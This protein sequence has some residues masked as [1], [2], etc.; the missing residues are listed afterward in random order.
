M[1]RYD[2]QVEVLARGACV[3][4]GRLLLCHSKGAANTFLPGGHVEFRERA[5]EALR[6]EIAEE[7][8]LDAKVGRFLGCVEHAFAQKG[9]PHAEVNLVFVVTIEGLSSDVAPPSK[10]EKIEFSWVDMAGLD[11]TA[12]EPAALRRELPRWLDP[13]F[14]GAGW[15]SW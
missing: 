12:L 5:E 9:Q 1:G 14:R 10:E 13:A 8:G 6:R 7:L 15:A 2:G 4:A 11:A 3:V